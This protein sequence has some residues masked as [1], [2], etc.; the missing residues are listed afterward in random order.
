MLGKG[1]TLVEVMIVMAIL[2]TLAVVAVPNFTRSRQKAHKYACISSLK[3]I[4]NAKE[5]WA[6]EA[7]SVSVAAPGWDDLVPLYLQS[8]PVC[9]AG[10]TYDIKDTDERP[11]C[12]IE[13]HSLS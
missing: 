12:T 4:D 11:T 2:A 13:G 8:I 1:F 3:G 9:P 10:R 7:G 6:V 5:I